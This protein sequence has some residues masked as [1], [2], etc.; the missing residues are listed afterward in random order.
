M[1]A[2]RWMKFWPGDWK[3]DAAL[4]MCGLAA[5]GLWIELIGIMHDAEPYGHLLVNGRAPSH[6][7]IGA[8]VGASERDAAKLLAELEDAGVFSRTADGVIYSRRME[9]DAKDSERGRE[10]IA[11][12]WAKKGSGEDGGG[13]GNTKPTSDPNRVGDSPLGSPETEAEAEKKEEPS[14]R[15]GSAPATGA[16]AKASG[17]SVDLPEWLP[18]SAWADWCQHRRG[19]AWTQRAAEL[20]IAE[21]AK[22]RDAGSEPQ[23]VIEQSIASGWR[24]LFPLKNSLGQR[25]APA[26]PR[27]AVGSWVDLMNAKSQPEYDIDGSAEE[28]PH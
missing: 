1:T 2:H 9:R 28:L 26:K 21:L 23:A 20:S 4:R 8:I 16:R 14:L 11:K 27:S 3:N 10:A 6:R 25:L 12:R 5:R 19:K 15:S 22:L 17:V 13:S 7:Q 18:A 24:G